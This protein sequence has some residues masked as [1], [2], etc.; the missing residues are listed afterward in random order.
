M[1]IL[2]CTFFYYLQKCNDSTLRG[3]ESTTHC[4][5]CLDLK[6]VVTQMTLHT[7]LVY[8]CAIVHAHFGLLGIVAHTHTNVIV[9]ATT[10]DVVGHFKPMIIDTIKI[11]ASLRHSGHIH[12]I[13]S[14]RFDQVLPDTYTDADMEFGLPDD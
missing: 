7:K 11:K 12:L 9:A 13:G 1:L 10:P 3:S 8:W 2:Q 4:W 5:I 14:G 6:V